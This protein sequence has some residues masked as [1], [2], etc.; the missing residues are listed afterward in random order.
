MLN[1][2][3]CPLGYSCNNPVGCFKTSVAFETAKLKDANAAGL[4]V[5][6]TPDE[7]PTFRIC[8]GLIRYGIITDESQLAVSLNPGLGERAVALLSNAG[9]VPELG[10]RAIETARIREEFGGIL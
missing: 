3:K 6:E 9:I 7:L 8:S 5:N 2:E 10:G 1:P 4:V